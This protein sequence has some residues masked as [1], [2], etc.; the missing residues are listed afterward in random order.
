MRRLQRREAGFNYMSDEEEGGSCSGGRRLNE[1]EEV[2][3]AIGGF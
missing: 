1:K 2:A 3:E